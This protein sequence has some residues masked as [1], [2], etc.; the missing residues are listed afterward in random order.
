MELLIEVHQEFL[1]TFQVCSL[2]VLMLKYVK[3]LPTRKSAA[4][5]I[6]VVPLEEQE[7]KSKEAML[8]VQTQ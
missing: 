6:E 7:V 5:S 4:S 2:N 1:S 8:S 3:Q